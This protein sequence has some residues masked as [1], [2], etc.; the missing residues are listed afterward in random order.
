[1]YRNITSKDAF[2]KQLAFSEQT[3]ESFETGNATTRGWIVKD[4]FGN[5]WKIIFT[6]EVGTFT[7]EYDC[8]IDNKQYFK[9]WIYLTGDMADIYKA[10]AHKRNIKSEKLLKHYLDIT[11]MASNYFRFGYLKL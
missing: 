4:R 5:R 7:V 2:E 3:I 8:E 1:M 6:R 10:Y 11:A 9:V